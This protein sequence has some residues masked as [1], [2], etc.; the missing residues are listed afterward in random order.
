MSV[1]YCS[2]LVIV[3]AVA[4]WAL[5]TWRVS[6][7]TCWNLKAL[8]CLYSSFSGLEDYLHS[9]RSFMCWNEQFLGFWG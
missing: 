5:L 4:L 8:Y 9:W 1:V 7:R 3:S 2:D 6:S